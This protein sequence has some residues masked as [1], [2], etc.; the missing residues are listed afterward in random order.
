MTV[1]VTSFDIFYSVR[2]ISLSLTV[3]VLLVP[4]D[5]ELATQT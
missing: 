2:F 1:H 5:Y 4:R 3:F